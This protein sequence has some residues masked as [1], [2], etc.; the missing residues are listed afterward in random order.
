MATIPWKS[1]IIVLTGKPSAIRGR[2]HDLKYDPYFEEKCDIF[3]R[4]IKKLNKYNCC[5]I[6]TTTLGIDDVYNSAIEYLST[7]NSPEPRKWTSAMRHVAWQG[8]SF[9]DG[10]EK[11]FRLFCLISIAT[12]IC[13]VVRGIL[14]VGWISSVLIS[15]IL[16][17]LVNFVVNSSFW[18]TAICDL[19]LFQPTGK[20]ALYQYLKEFRTRATFCDAILCYCLFGSI[21]R[22]NFHDAS[23]LDM[24][25]IRRPGFQNALRVF[26]YI[27]SERLYALLHK[28]PIELW[29]GDSIDFLERLRSDEIPV[30]IINNDEALERYYKRTQTIE[31]AIEANGDLYLFHKSEN[32]KDRFA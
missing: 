16:A 4:I 17:H 28:V 27:L 10:S 12:I 14:N 7:A 6:D 21:A 24:V 13:G 2:K 3:S 31:E 9:M 30:V 23:D 20:R 22:N 5:S 29:V 8:M 26:T 1:K 19:K 15:A 25:L 18:A 11:L 32:I